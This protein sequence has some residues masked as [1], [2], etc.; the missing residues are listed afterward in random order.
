MIEQTS[1]GLAAADTAPPSVTV[2]MPNGGETFKPGQ[3]VLIQWTSVDNVGVVAH[4]VLFSATGD[5]PFE[6]IAMGL[7]GWQTYF[8]WTVPGR[9]TNTGRIRVIARDAAG[10][11]AGDKTDGFFKIVPDVGPIILSVRPDSIPVGARSTLKVQ[12]QNLL[13]P[14]QFNVLDPSTGYAAYGVSI[15]PPVQGIPD[16]VNLVLDV[17]PNTPAKPNYILQAL[18][19]GVASAQANLAITAPKGKEKEYDKIIWE[20]YTAPWPGATQPMSVT[21]A[22]LRQ[23]EDDMQQMRHFIRAELRPDLHTDN[24]S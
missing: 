2:I 5:S 23:L 24:G 12:G 15:V 16:G 6:P 14:T 4:D 13:Y 9:F 11:Q 21:E 8:Y 17:S 7:P 10:N 1:Q 20:G 22:R 19:P 18:Q 3:L